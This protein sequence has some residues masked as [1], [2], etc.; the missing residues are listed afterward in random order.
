MLQISTNF[1]PY[2]LRVERKAPV[3]LKVSIRNTGGQ[4]VLASYQID[5]PF[6]LSFDKTGFRA[7]HEKKLGALEP[8]KAF[9]EYVEIHARPT[10]RQG[11]YTI[12]VKAMEHY[13]NYDFVMK[14]YTK[15]VELVVEN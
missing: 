4:A 10:T 1:Q 13:S 7:R 14:N 8:G 5:L 11:T 3:Q 12:A 9:Q 15:K 2:R 6:T